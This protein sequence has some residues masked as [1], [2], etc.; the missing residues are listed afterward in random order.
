MSPLKIIALYALLMVVIACKGS[1]GEGAVTAVATPIVEAPFPSCPEDGFPRHAFLEAFSDKTSSG[2]SR[3][4]QWVGSPSDQNRHVILRSR[5]VLDHYAASDPSRLLKKFI[6]DE[7]YLHDDFNMLHGPTI[8][9]SCL[10]VLDEGKA[11][12]SFSR[13]YADDSHELAGTDV[14]L[15]LALDGEHGQWRIVDAEVRDYCLLGVANDPTRC[16]CVPDLPPPPGPAAIPGDA[17]RVLKG[18]DKF[19]LHGSRGRGKHG[20]W[21]DEV[22]YPSSVILHSPDDVAP[23]CKGAKKPDE[24]QVLLSELLSKVDFSR[25]VAYFGVQRRASAPR[26][27]TMAYWVDEGVL[28]I[29]DFALLDGGCLGTADEWLSTTVLAINRSQVTKILVGPEGEAVHIPQARTL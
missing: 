7:T 4:T 25:E 22:P 23:L 5:H 24:C 29:D 18:D 2:R 12:A 20:P 26:V 8:V 9:F 21:R 13:S 11:V 10:D 6:E 28:Q 14:R 3:I 19:V 15:H 1:S 27:R 16:L 17:V